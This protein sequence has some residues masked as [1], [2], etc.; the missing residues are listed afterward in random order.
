M[1]SG[2]SVGP[3]PSSR[4]VTEDATPGHR[5]RFEVTA[6][7]DA[8]CSSD[9]TTWTVREDDK[10]T[11]RCVQPVRISVSSTEAAP[12]DRV[13]I[14]GRGFS[15]TTR[16][17]LGRTELPIEARSRTT[18]VAVIPQTATTGELRLSC[19][20]LQDTDPPLVIVV[21]RPKL[22]PVAQAVVTKLKPRQ[23]TLDGTTSYDQNEGGRIV[24]YRWTLG[25]KLVSRKAAFTRSFDAGKHR[26]RLTVINRYG[27]KDSTRVTVAPKL[28]VT[29]LTLP[30][31]L[32]CFDCHTLSRTA[33]RIVGKS[34]AYA[35]GARRVQVTGHTDAVGSDAYNLAL[36]RRRTTSV[37]RALLADLRPRPRAVTA[38]GYGE[39]RPVASNKTAAGRAKNRRVELTFWRW[40]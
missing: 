9:S 19:D 1:S 28:Q 8:G 38:R 2:N 4:T 37:R 5:Y 17:H 35:R 29:R 16:A 13:E 23:Y 6:C 27:L 30:D 31:V 3:C 36:S 26:L 21:R 20:D 24:A 22:P 40:Q 39:R 14:R 25:G 33:A 15:T 32:F 34:R 7:N 10:P 18:M 12:G 11:D